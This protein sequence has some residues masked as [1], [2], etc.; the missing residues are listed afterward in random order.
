MKLFY[1]I[2]ILSIILSVNSLPIQSYESSSSSLSSSSSSTT[3][4]ND[5]NEEVHPDCNNEE[6]IYN[7]KLDDLVNQ[8]TTHWK[9]DHLDSI[10]SMSN[11]HT[12]TQI[13]KHIQINVRSKYNENNEQQQQH[14]MTPT[15]LEENMDMNVLIAQISDAIQSHTLGKISAIWDRL[16]DRLGKQTLNTYIR[17]LILDTCGSSSE[18]E[19]VKSELLESEELD[20]DEVKEE[21][22][23]LMDH[24]QRQQE[25]DDDDEETIVINSQCLNHHAQQLSSSLDR[26]IGNHL[27][28]IFETMD[29]EELPALLES[30]VDNLNGVLDY[31]N[32]VFLGDSSLELYLQATPWKG[33][34]KK[35]WLNTILPKLN[36]NNVHNPTVH[37][38]TR[39]TCL[40]KV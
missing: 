28:T 31:F 6:P 4:A 1:L 8:I 17:T 38:F 40:A 23:A 22:M 26:Y 32:N 24:Q 36:K 20:S 21:L 9:F 11:G 29:Q 35:T 5:I 25:R 30:T 33:S 14:I 12:T 34:I 15:S 10:Q 39:Y 2:C 18:L 3:I 27:L 13:K 16:G 37:F 7:V 19:V